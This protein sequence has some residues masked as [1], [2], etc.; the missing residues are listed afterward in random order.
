MK[1]IAAIQMCSVPD[2][3]ENLA[4]AARMPQEAAE[5]GAQ[6]AVLLLRTLVKS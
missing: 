3:D 5:K 2:V 6:L 1:K 4:V